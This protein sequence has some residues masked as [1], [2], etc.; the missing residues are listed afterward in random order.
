MYTLYISVFLVK[1]CFRQN[2]RIS[3]DDAI[4]LCLQF[5]AKHKYYTCVIN[6]VGKKRLWQ[7]A[8]FNKKAKYI[9][10]YLHCDMSVRLS[11][12]LPLC[13]WQRRGQ[14]GWLSFLVCKL[15]SNSMFLRLHHRKIWNIVRTE[16]G[17]T[18]LQ[19][20]YCKC[21]TSLTGRKFD[22]VLFRKK[23]LSILIW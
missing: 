12:C 15:L 18:Y 23:P 14:C 11:H 9:L 2:K 7:S 10:R 4:I 6:A 21:H 3:A 8:M 5:I 17:T 16:M 13:G 19:I 20:Q 1:S 22:S